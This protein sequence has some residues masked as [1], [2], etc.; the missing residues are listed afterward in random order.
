MNQPTLSL[1]LIRLD[2]PIHFKPSPLT[3]PVV[4]N[5]NDTTQD[6]MVPIFFRGYPIVVLLVVVVEFDGRR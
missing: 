3:L 1:S 6:L 5:G 2:R 4:V